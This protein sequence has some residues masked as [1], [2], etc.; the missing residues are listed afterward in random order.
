MEIQTSIV[1]KIHA[2]EVT[3]VFQ[4]FL[5]PA[6]QTVLCSNSE[7][8]RCSKE[9]YVAISSIG[10]ARMKSLNH[11]YR[12]KGSSTDILSFEIHEA[13]VWGELYVSPADIAKNAKMMG[14]SVEYELIEILVHGFLHLTG[15]D[16]CDEM[17]DWQKKLTDNIITIYETTRR[18]R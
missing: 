12:Q 6:V 10:E 14:H 18:S 9:R 5:L 3:E 11:T 15:L 17:F 4:L 2:K 13:D 8:S 16:H 7:I 1:T